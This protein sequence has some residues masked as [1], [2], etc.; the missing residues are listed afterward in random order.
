MT[1]SFVDP[2]WR[3]CDNDITCCRRVVFLPRTDCSHIDCIL[4]SFSSTPF[5]GSSQC[6]H[7]SP[8][9]SAL[10]L[11]SVLLL[12]VTFFVLV[13]RHSWHFVLHYASVCHVCWSQILN[14]SRHRVAASYRTPC[15]DTN[16]L[17]D[18]RQMEADMSLK[19]RGRLLWK[20]NTLSLCGMRR[21]WSNRSS[22]KVE[23]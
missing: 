8:S 10:F 16:G 4:L 6:S 3:I 5:R 15:A 1:P 11:C 23:D 22:I 20:M 19:L 7:V 12:Y 17:K 21:L 18:C 14:V 2:V 13:C 9:F